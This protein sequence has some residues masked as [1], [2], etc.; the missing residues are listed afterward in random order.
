MEHIRQIGSSFNSN[1]SY[2]VVDVNEWTLPL[3]S[4]P[5]IVE[6]PELFEIVDCEIPSHFQYLIYQNNNN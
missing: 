3:T 5:S 6:N 4:H 2:I 1:E